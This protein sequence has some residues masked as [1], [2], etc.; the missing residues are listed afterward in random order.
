MR[1]ILPTV[2]VLFI[3][4]LAFAIPAD[5]QDSGNNNSG[6]PVIVVVGESLVRRVPDVAYLNVSVESKAGNPRDAQRQNADTMAAVER[7]LANA[8][9]ARD[10]LRTIGAWLDQQ[11]DFVNGKRVSR[12]YTARNTLEI[13]VDDVA[14]AGEIADVAVQAGAT[15]VSGVRFDLKDRTSAEREALRQAVEDARA[16][17]DAAA[18]GAGRTIDRVIRI[19]DAR[20][21]RG[22]RPVQ[23]TFAVARAAEASSAP[24]NF[25]PGMLEINAQ[26]TLTVS[27]KYFPAQWD[28]KL[29]IHVT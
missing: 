5:A 21:D 6:P 20:P 19:E 15:A 11:Y 17:A 10:A 22:P 9:I 12:G 8:G 27:M 26:V 18:S 1:R 3:L 29:G 16:R 28:P 2:A 4:S 14:R 24:T 25:E 13:R 23:Q 7:A